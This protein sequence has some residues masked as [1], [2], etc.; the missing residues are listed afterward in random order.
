MTNKEEIIAKVYLDLAGFGSINETLKDAKKYDKTI[1]YDD[2]KRWKS[3][4]AFGQKSQ[5]K[6][7]EQF[8][9]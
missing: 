4:Q 5:G 7:S 1:T 9:C 6:R 3:K 8:H 2:V